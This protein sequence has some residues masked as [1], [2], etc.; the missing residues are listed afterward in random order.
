MR[1]LRHQVLALWLAA[2]V[3]SQAALAAQAR[4]DE[5]LALRPP[6]TV[7]LHEGLTEGLSATSVG[8]FGWS[9]LD[10]PQI[11][12][13]DL[14]VE[15]VVPGAIQ[16]TVAGRKW[17][18]AFATSPSAEAATR[19]SLEG[20]TSFRTDPTGVGVREGWQKPAFDDRLGTRFPC[21]AS[22]RRRQ[23]PPP[24]AG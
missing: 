11:E 21:P 23:S 3:G 19:L 1:W 8:R 16:R 22:G 9:P 6:G 10:D 15:R 17:E 24:A 20:S 13:E 18:L 5:R 2:T 4:R 14:L 7:A 12:C